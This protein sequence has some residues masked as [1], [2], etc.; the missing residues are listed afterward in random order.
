MV[1]QIL[2][3]TG[4]I[5]PVPEISAL[6]R[7][8]GVVSVIDGAQ[9]PGHIPVDL[10]ELGCDF[11]VASG[12]KWLLGPKE[13]GFLFVREEWLERWRPS[14]VGAYSDAGFDLEAG[15]FHRLRPASASEY[16]TR[17]TPLLYGFQAGLDFLDS[18]GLERVFQRGASLAR[19]LREGVEGMAGV[20][21]LTPLDHSAAILTFRL[22][23]E[24]GGGGEW[25][26]RIRRDHRIRLRPVGEA[27][28]NAVRAST[29]LFNT[30]DEVDSLV[31]ILR[32]LV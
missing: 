5:L 12:H 23:Q 7:E 11:Y 26:N 1:S 25:V 27:G 10:H 18:V 31:H 21:V 19:R 15:R 14:Y 3:T 17:S 22:P 6:C 8:R 28:L 29:H 13:T 20:E 16:G 2:C 9:C 24:G 30:E 4:T 32:E